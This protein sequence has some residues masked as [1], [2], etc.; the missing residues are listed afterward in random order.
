M[1]SAFVVVASSVFCR[2]TR[3]CCADAGLL[4]A[5][6]PALEAAQCA[7]L[8]AD[9]R[10]GRLP[11]DLRAAQ[12]WCALLRHALEA[13]CRRAGAAE[14]LSSASSASRCRASRRAWSGAGFKSRRERV[15]DELRGMR[16]ADEALFCCSGVRGA[17]ALVILGASRGLR[18]VRVP[19]YRR[20]VA[21]VLRR[22]EPRRVCSLCALRF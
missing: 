3:R 2:P 22:G 21:A 14:A 13:G 6:E 11:R 7:A 19:A 10:R 8:A 17:V 18:H 5:R 12:A 4:P 9:A 20:A 1:P 16:C 15:R